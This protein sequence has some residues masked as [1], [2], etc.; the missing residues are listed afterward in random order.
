MDL[1]GIQYRDTG[2]SRLGEDQREFGTAQDQAVDL[3]LLHHFFYDIDQLFT[4]VIP[5]NP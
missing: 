4:G 5:E 3:L 2:I 1:R